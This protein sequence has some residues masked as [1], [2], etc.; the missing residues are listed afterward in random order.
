M[1]KYDLIC[2]S[3]AYLYS[4]TVL[5]GDSLEIHGYNL[6]RCDHSTNNKHGGVCFYYKSFFPLKVLNMKHLQEC[7]NIEFS[8]GNKICRLIS[9]YRYPSQNQKEFTTFL[10]NLESA[11]RLYPFPIPFLQF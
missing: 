7:L 9:L 4:S 1:H 8:I 11:Y 3:E 2:L 5:E 10:D 6:V